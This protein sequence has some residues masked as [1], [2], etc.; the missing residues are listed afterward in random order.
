MVGRQPTFTPRLS[1]G[2]L[3]PSPAVSR[4]FA[5]LGPADQYAVLTHV[6]T[7]RGRARRNGTGI[8]AMAFRNGKPVMMLQCKHTGNTSPGPPRSSGTPAAGRPK[9]AAPGY[10][11]AHRTRHAAP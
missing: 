5:G 1:S 3:A 9:P 6:L 10:F 8:D 7:A 4:A 11:P 2:C